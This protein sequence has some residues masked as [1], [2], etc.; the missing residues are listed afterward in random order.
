MY[1]CMYVIYIHAYVCMKLCMLCVHVCMHLCMNVR[2]HLCMLRG[3][4]R[5]RARQGREVIRK[6]VGVIERVVASRYND[7]ICETLR[8]TFAK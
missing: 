5:R 6:H 4:R 8:V 2:M 3:G 7:S 1:V